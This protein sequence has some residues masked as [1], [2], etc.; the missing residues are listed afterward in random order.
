MLPFSRA[1][2]I[3]VLAFVA[4][5]SG[6]AYGGYTVAKNSL[7]HGP[8]FDCRE[9]E[10]TKVLDGDTIEVDGNETVRLIGIDAP[11]LS[12]CYGP[13]AKAAL[14]R[15]VLGADV[16]LIKDTTA[17]DKYGRLLRY[18]YTDNHN[19]EEGIYS[20][21]YDLVEHGSAR[22]YFT[23]ENNRYYQSYTLA[24]NKAEEAGEGMWSQCEYEQVRMRDKDDNAREPESAECIIKGN[25]NIAGEHLYFLPTCP[26]YSQIKINEHLGEQYFCTEAEAQA[27]GFTISGSCGNVSR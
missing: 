12:A 20:I 22:A 1:V 2:I 27:A 7:K 10:V 24:E 26:N 14:E 16:T 18:V 17:V 3:S 11:E 8:L 13:E 6:G 23:K 19:P 15:L 21:N 5:L 4:S 25:V 9:H